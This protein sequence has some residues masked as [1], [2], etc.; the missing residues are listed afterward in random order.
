MVKVYKENEFILEFYD[1]DK[2]IDFICDNNYTIYTVYNGGTNF[3]II[4]VV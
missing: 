3:Q 4:E 1:I 2:A